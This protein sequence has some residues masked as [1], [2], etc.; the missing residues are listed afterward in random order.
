MIP[1]LAMILGESGMVCPL[2]VI[3]T[4]GRLEEVFKEI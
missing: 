3:T 1:I 4:K 2:V